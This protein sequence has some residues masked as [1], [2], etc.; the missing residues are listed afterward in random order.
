MNT[1]PHD[2]SSHTQPPENISM[3]NWR[4]LLRDVTSEY[5][6]VFGIHPHPEPPEC[7]ICRRRHGNEI[8]HACE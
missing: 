8:Q 5:P 6:E 7:Y 3:G 2:E 1:T 4:Q